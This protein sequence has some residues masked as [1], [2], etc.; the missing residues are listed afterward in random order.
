LVQVLNLRSLGPWVLG[1]RFWVSGLRSQFSWA[2]GPRAEVWLEARRSELRASFLSLTDFFNS[3]QITSSLKTGLNAITAR[4]S[5]W[6]AL[7]STR[8]L[9]VDPRAISVHSRGILREGGNA[10]TGG[11]R[12][13]IHPYLEDIKSQIEIVAKYNTVWRAS[14]SI[15]IRYSRVAPASCRLSRARPAP[16]SRTARP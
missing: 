13:L 6:M 3:L 16:A 1:L 9:V 14:E 11:K 12:V 5:T 10:A 4:L 7:R 15:A 8:G 2:L